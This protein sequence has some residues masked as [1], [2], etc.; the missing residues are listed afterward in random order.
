MEKDKSAKYEELI[1][2]IDN[3]SENE[4]EVKCYLDTH[5]T[6]EAIFIKPEELGK[7]VNKMRE[8][9]KEAEQIDVRVISAEDTAELKF[10]SEK[11]KV[12]VSGLKK[13]NIMKMRKQVKTRIE[14][15]KITEWI[16]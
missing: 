15:I 9:A 14:R 10:L 6:R 3:T 13:L 12:L 8:T 7:T 5:L 16:N 11:Q 2:L 4:E 1:L